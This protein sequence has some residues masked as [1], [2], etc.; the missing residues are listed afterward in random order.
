MPISLLHRKPFSSIPAG[1]VPPDPHPTAH[2]SAFPTSRFPSRSYL[3]F[4][5]AASNQ[6]F[7]EWLLPGIVSTGRI[8]RLGNTAAVLLVTPSPSGALPGPAQAQNL[9]SEQLSLDYS[10]LVGYPTLK[11]G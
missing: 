8:H 7:I 5:V 9:G 6:R 1:A 11:L 10:S 4:K 3:G 2:P